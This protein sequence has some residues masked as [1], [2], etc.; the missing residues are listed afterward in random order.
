MLLRGC[1]CCRCCCCW[2]RWGRWQWASRGRGGYCCCAIA[3]AVAVA[4]AVAVAAAAARQQHALVVLLQAL[5][6]IDCSGGHHHGRGIAVIRQHRRG[7]HRGCCCCRWC[8]ISGSRRGHIIGIAVAVAGVVRYVAAVAA[9][10]ETGCTHMIAAVVIAVV[11][12]LLIANVAAAA[13]AT[14]AAV[15]TV[16]ATA[17]ATAAAAATAVCWLH[18]S[19][20]G[21]LVMTGSNHVVAATAGDTANSACPAPAASS[22]GIDVERCSRHSCGRWSSCCQLAPH[23]VSHRRQI[24]PG[25]TVAAQQHVAYQRFNWRFSD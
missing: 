17:D 18:D 14:A 16:V 2:R 1:C 7:V 20:I 21:E 10:E 25:E 23:R 22:A 24:G 11:V 4:I 15:V 12:D 6:C 9:A 19:N 5:I 8:R 3:V 13:A